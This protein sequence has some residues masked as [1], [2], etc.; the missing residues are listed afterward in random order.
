MSEPTPSVALESLTLSI[1]GM[2]C[3]ACVARVEKALR[4]VDGVADAAVNFAAETATVRGAGLGVD[5]LKKAVA[6]AGYGVAGV[7]EGEGGEDEERA[8][9]E[10]AYRS[11]R[12]RLAVSAVLS[13][14]VMGLSLGDH[15]PGLD[16][17]PY[18]TAGVLMFLLTTPVLFWCGWRFLT[19]FWTALRHGTADMNSLI[20]VGTSAAYLYSAVATFFPEAFGP[21]THHVQRHAPSSGFWSFLA[22]APL[23]HYYYDTT[24]MIIA[25]ILLGRLL[26]ARARGR[27]SEAIRKL[28][29]LRPKTARIRREGAEMDVP[30]QDVRVGDGVVVRPGE[31]L[32]VDGIILE[33][34]ST[35]DESMLT[36]EGLPVDKTRG[37]EVTGGTVNQTGS[38]VYRA[39]RVGADT[40]LS[41]IVR[42]VREAQG[43]KAP[44]QR[45]ADRIAAVFVPIV[46]GVAVATFLVWYLARP[47][48]GP[49]FA[50]IN[51][52]SVLIIA[53][54]C[55]L[56]LAT[57]AAVMVGTGRGAELGVLIKGGEAL[58][59]A[60]RVTSVVLDKTGTITRGRPEVTDLLP[61]PGMDA[62]DLLRAAASAERRS[63]HP[64]GQAIV[65]KAGAQELTLAEP[66]GFQ[67]LSGH[68]IEA[69]VEGRR[70]LVGNRRLM[71]E[72][73]V[74]IEALAAQAEGLSARGGTSLFVAFDGRAAG[75]IGV[76]DGIK[77]E[78][79][80]AIARLREMGLDVAMLTG[81]NPRAAGAV[82]GEVGIQ[83]VL[84]EVLPQDKAERVR[85]L[86]AEGR[87]V[88]MVGDGINDAPALAS[89]D[90]G[91]AIGTG[92]DVA[93]ES[94]DIALMSG[95]LR[96]VGTAI[97]LSRRMMRTI[98]QN[99]FWAF[100]YNVVG[101]PVAA[102]V[103]YPFTGLLLHPVLASAAMAFSSV[104]VVANS[105]RLRR[106]KA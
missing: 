68:G 95:D 69:A 71:A 5:A 83:K 89:A 81:D 36:G 74:E 34:A 22:S 72:R 97:A 93:V 106:F 15:V 24:A 91:I 7:V 27:A 86:R 96:G 46:F 53:C 50:L 3:A 65:R 60:G 10:R 45:Q 43:S 101:I 70:V 32:P 20:A 51:F 48:L 80:D 39:T 11:L 79:K 42:L 33:G 4:G 62:G 30:A 6:S 99:L 49:S 8:E 12:L 104:S 66:Q 84:A 58:E 19:G 92:T 38:F 63:E 13:A 44:V 1:R 103:L 31:S 75:L 57:P 85:A 28:M 9:R 78:A 100:A 73:G 82:A 87:V 47:D 26:E 25:L 105:L 55:A 64:L 29:G 90:V 59:T 98:R 77:P 94:A 61:A 54:P 18:R 21:A 52:I 41:Q 102:G 16:A 17:V 67:S 76:A 88:A 14:L 23:V 35:L 2:T 40:A 56:G 37:D